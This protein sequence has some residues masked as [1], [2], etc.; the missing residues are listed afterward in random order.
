MISFYLH[1]I[2]SVLNRKHLYMLFIFV[3]HKEEQTVIRNHNLLRYICQF[4][5]MEDIYQL[6]LYDII[7]ILI[8]LLQVPYCT[9]K[10]WWLILFLLGF[11]LRRFK[12][13]LLREGNNEFEVRRTF[14][15]ANKKFFMGELQNRASI[16]FLYIYL[17]NSSFVVEGNEEGQLVTYY[18]NNSSF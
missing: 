5:K 4:V 12:T 10:S 18:V 2:R 6:E 17:E 7:S 14:Y 11:L 1:H 16:S 3:E 13:Y 9:K 15:M 8:L